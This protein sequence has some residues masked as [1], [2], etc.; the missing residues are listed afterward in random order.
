MH[1]DKKYQTD[2]T[3]TI[4]QNYPEI[5]VLVDAITHAGG[6]AILVG[7]AVRDLL[8]G[9][10]T[11]DIDIEVHG[12]SLDQLEKLLKAFGHV[13]LVGK[14]FGVLRVDGIDA[15]F[16]LPRK[17]SKGRK[18]EVV[19]DPSMSI[20]DAFRRRDLTINAMGID[21][22]SYE[23]LDPFGGQKD[24]KNGVLRAIDTQLFQD[25]PLRFY[26]VMQFMARFDMQPNKEL[27]ALCKTIDLS[28]VS[29]ERIEEEFAKML[30]KSN[31]PSIGIRWLRNIGRLKELFPEIADLINVPQRQDYHPEGDVFEH[32]MQ[33]V[34]EAALL[35][36]GLNEADRLALMYA[37]LCHDL[38]KVKTTKEVGGIL[39][40]YGHAQAG[41]RLAQDLLR[42]ITRNNNLIE[43][44]KK[45]VN[46]HM[47]P[48]G[49]VLN[50]A[51][52]AAYK[53]LARK[54]APETNI[55]MLTLLAKAD[56]LARKGS[57]GIVPQAPLEQLD[58]FINHARDAH[59]EHKPED[60][61]LQGR[62]IIDIV[63][64]G[65]HMGELLAKAYDIQLEE[66]VHDKQILKERVKKLV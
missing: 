51:K 11:K 32:T 27:E 21:L 43:T 18:P 48:L 41:E 62:D 30:L 52:P 33:A 42:R 37:A 8:L 59:V 26:R 22:K 63:Q 13:R 38:G 39:R 10:P 25:D 31:N 7:G 50:K 54:L 44:V 61:V 35:S 1:L 58:I 23:L 46:Y 56:R 57:D 53:R 34:D 66:G 16:S 9:M 5:P 3:A 4:A 28:H 17:D 12:I 29:I 14:Q 40:S 47:E 45:L 24:L 15:D 2:L 60:P 55:A 6:R 49:L 65:P 20:E 19:I 36:K 64:P